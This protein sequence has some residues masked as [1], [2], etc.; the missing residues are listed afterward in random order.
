MPW[1]GA[2]DYVRITNCV[3]CGRE[4]YLTQFICRECQDSMDEEFSEPCSCYCHAGD[5]DCRVEDDAARSC[6]QDSPYYR[7]KV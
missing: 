4:A 2:Q 1:A 7:K 3:E 6:C 5:A